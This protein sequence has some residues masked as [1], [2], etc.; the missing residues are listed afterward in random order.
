[1]AGRF[2]I[3]GDNLELLFK[4]KADNT[5]LKAALDEASLKIRQL[6]AG[7]KGAGG[8]ATVHG[9]IL[10]HLASHSLKEIQSAVQNATNEMGAFGTAISSATAAIGEVAGPIG[11]AIGAI[12]IVA[13]TVAAAGL[14]IFELTKK[15]AEAALELEHMVEQTGLSAKT[16]TSL[17][18]AADESGKSIEGL[19]RGMKLFELTVAQAAQGSD[20]AGEALKRLGIT[21]KEALQDLD[22]ALAKVFKRIYEAPE[23]IE[24][25]SLAADAFGK[26][27]GPQ[28]I[29]L[30]Q[31]F[32]GNLGELIKRAE[33]LGVTLDEEGIRS[34]AEF[35]KNMNALQA[36]AA[37][38]ARTFAVEVAPV[39]TDALQDIS[40]YLSE[41]K[42]NFKTWGND[43]ADIV[44]GLAGIVHSGALQIAVDIA[45]LNP[46]L[47]GLIQGAKLL[48]KYGADLRAESARNA[49]IASHPVGWGAMSPEAQQE[50]VATHPFG[51]PGDSAFGFR[52][53]PREKG[54]LEEG[55]D[56]R[57]GGGGGGKSSLAKQTEEEKEAEKQEKAELKLLEDLGKAYS[58]A[59]DQLNLIDIS[60]HH[61]AVEQSIL[62]GV[63]SKASEETQNAAL[64]EAKLADNK[65]RNL[66]LQN[67][68]K[69]Y[70][71][72]QRREVNAGTEA[73]KSYLEKS[74][75]FIHSLE[76][77]GAILQ[78]LTK[79]WIQFN[80]TLLDVKHTIESMPKFELPPPPGYDPAKPKG[81]I[82]PP[83]D[84]P[85]PMR[86]I[87]SLGERI[88]QVFDKAGK[89]IAGA[90]GASE[91]AGLQ[92]AGVMQGALDNLARGIGSL[93]ENYVLLG[94]TGP[95][96]LKKL[97]AAT[98]AKVAGE[99]AVYAVYYTAM[100][101]ADLFWN[102]A[103]SAADFTAA[104]LFASIAGVAAVAGRAIAGDSFKQNNSASGSGGSSG[105]SGGSSSTS[106]SPKPIDIGRRQGTNANAPVIQVHLHGDIADERIVNV[107]V[108]NKIIGGK[109]R[110]L[111]LNNGVLVQ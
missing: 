87:I 8:A 33:E 74:Q 44:S 54:A 84:A 78:P 82:G 11:V 69:T 100:S 12:A 13:T 36:Q 25:V 83:G 99:A 22:G 1:M 38:L 49:E 66:K 55:L 45:R 107:V 7:H 110:Q 64:A 50:W 30:I 81:A 92:L 41:N 91:E 40:R 68:V 59:Q 80:A 27:I 89:S 86:L 101:I 62:N 14:A 94:E 97:L 9:N 58:K 98:L 106:S 104:A 24:K 79:F 5:S 20:K 15:A 93:V 67:E 88:T 102:P 2:S 42:Q 90:F 3:M 17:K 103:Q 32:H 57:R 52:V 39:L 19:G 71:V 18:F 73:Q 6:E 56:I 53:G 51:A 76:N 35:Q 75:D 63:L 31:A 48:A 85:A 95:A 29:P 4:L 28:L 37:G 61:Y 96:A 72:E 43:V 26:R 105:S 21:S 109:I 47:E 23:G 16:I 60:T 10:E 108:K 77:Q 70:L 65:E 34:L 46:M 111:D